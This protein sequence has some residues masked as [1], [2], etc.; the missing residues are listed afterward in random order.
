MNN[1]H[2]PSIQGEINHDVL[3]KVLYG[4]DTR[5]TNIGNVNQHKYPTL[6]TET[7]S[8]VTF[9]SVVITAGLTPTVLS[10]RCTLTVVNAYTFA[11]LDESAMFLC[12]H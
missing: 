4:D 7:L 1:T 5:Y 10:P 6:F 11:L 3:H 8:H 9:V 2:P 12:S